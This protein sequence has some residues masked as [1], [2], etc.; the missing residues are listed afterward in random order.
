MKEI[1]TQLYPNEQ[2]ATAVGDY[3]F[4]HSTPLPKHLVE[5][6]AWGVRNS[7]RPDYM[8][9]PLQA[10]FQLWFAKAMGVKRILEIGTYIGFSTMGWAEA[11]GPQGYVTGLEVSAEYAKVAQESFAKYGITNVELIIGDAQRSIKNLA[12]VGTEPYDL[13][14]ID[15]DKESYPAYLS[16]I[17]KYSQSN[18]NSPRLLRPGG[19]ILADNTLRRGLV[20]DSTP[21]NPWHE[22]QNQEVNWRPGDME[23]LDTF[24]KNLVNNSRLATFLMPMFDGIGMARLVN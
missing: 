10:G 15:A 16:L 7:V 5:H 3:A 1:Y 14:F 22:K 19:I 18:S 6:H 2:V 9:S 13:I 4:T 8:I 17:L 20:A 21:A 23:G 12:I 24:N 11:V